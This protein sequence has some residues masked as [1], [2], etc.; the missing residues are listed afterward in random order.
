MH[1]PSQTHLVPLLFL[2]FF[3]VVVVGACS[4]SDQPSTVTP[5]PTA[6]QVAQPTQTPTSTPTPSPEP[7][8][9][10]LT[11]EAMVQL[12]RDE[13]SHSNDLEWWYFNGHLATENG[14]EFSYHYV[15][16][17][18]ILP[19]GLTSRLAQMSLADHTNGQHLIHEEAAFTMDKAKSGEFDVPVGDLRMNGNGDVYYL[20]FGTGDYSVELEA[21]SQR[22]PVLHHGTGLVDLGIAGKTYYYSRTRLQTSGTVSV[23]GV[24]HVVTGLSWMDHQWG[25][26][27]TL[28][29]GWDWLSLNL[30]DG[31]D[32]TISVVWERES[33]KP[34]DSYGTYV[35]PDSPAIHLPGSDI[36][37]RSTGSWTSPANGAVYPM[38]WNLKV[39]SLGLDL[40]LAP[41]SED[42]EFTLTGFVPIVYWE[43]SIQANGTRQGAPVAGQGFV[44]M[45]GYAPIPELPTAPSTRP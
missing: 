9:A 21:V 3:L 10:P 4:S 29:I 28:N 30:D 33:R 17:Q 32:L 31:S 23:A 6:T 24:P 19:P 7:T 2:S 13:G 16:F 22:P 8:L 36:F 40:T 35:P 42:A 27:T 45:V 15:T 5:A 39:E 43:G 11:A 25:D 26:F 14:E 18:S 44:E 38:G 20:K 12:P 34:I 1:I 37:L 41:S